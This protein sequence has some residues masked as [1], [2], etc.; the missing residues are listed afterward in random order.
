MAAPMWRCALEAL[1][2]N[3]MKALLRTTSIIQTVKRCKVTGTETNQHR[4][5]R[6]QNVGVSE[7]G[8]TILLWHPKEKFPYEHSKPIPRDNLHLAEGDSALRVQHR[9]SDKY[10]F[11]PTGPN[12]SELSGM[13]FTTKHRWYPKPSKKYRKRHPPKDRDGL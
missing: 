13:F 4:N 9:I 11:K 8:R 7:D 3:Q 5:F 1:R 10:R 2:T 6:K 12:I